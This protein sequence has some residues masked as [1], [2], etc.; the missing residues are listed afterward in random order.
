[1]AFSFLKRM[2]AWILREIEGHG[3]GAEEFF[4]LPTKELVGRLGIRQDH[5]FD[6]NSR[7]AA[8]SLAEKEWQRISGHNITP[9]FLLDDNYPSRLAEVEDAPVILYKLGEGDLEEGH[10]VSI[11]GTRKPTP[12]GLD[13][14][15]RFVKDFGD[16]FPNGAIV[17]GLAYGVD[18][19]AHKQSL[20]SGVR[21]IAVVAHGLNMIYPAAHRNLAKEIIKQGGAIL[22]EYPFDTQ[23]FKPHFLA[24]NRIVAGLSDVTVVVESKI[25]GGAMSTAH[26]AFM[27]NREVM[28]LP[29]RAGDELSSGCNQLIRKNKAHLIEC[30]ADMIELTGWSP[31]NSKSIVNQRD[32]FE[33]L[34]EEEEKI[35]DTLQGSCEPVTMDELVHG[36]GITAS[37][38]MGILGEMEFEGIIR[39]YPG[40]RFGV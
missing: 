3:V 27:N 20:E 1:M 11:V 14:C 21:T 9:L 12:Y 4:R 36:T 16:Y 23:P 34:N 17:S 8:L 10:F 7:D 2:N 33:E 37:K 15:Q 31:V 32:L 25:K 22:S 19:A 6:R 5:E 35:Y 24:R 30:A 39:R 29:G 18:A 40:G 38:L 26:N 13:F 28:A